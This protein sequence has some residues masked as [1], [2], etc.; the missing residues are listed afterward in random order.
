MK[1]WIAFLLTFCLLVA[2]PLQAATPK[3][4]PS[5]ENVTL[6]KP[7]LYDLATADSYATIT[8][9][10][11]GVSLTGKAY[12]KRVVIGKGVTLTLKD[13]HIDSSDDY[14][15]ITA[16]G[17]GCGLVLVG[18]NN[19]ESGRSYAGVNVP[20]TA[21]LVI[22]GSGKLT[23]RSYDDGAGIGGNSSQSN[24]RI[25]IRNAT[26]V[27]TG[28]GGGAGI[29]G[30]YRGNGSRIAIINAS[31]TA[32]SGAAGIGGGYRGNGSHIAIVNSSVT[33][34][35][36]AA[37]IGGGSGDDSGDGSHIA[38][39]N[40]SVTANGREAGIGGGYSRNGS[41]IVITASAVKAVGGIG[42]AGI[43]GGDSGNGSDITVDTV[44][45][46]QAS[47]G[48]GNSRVGGGGGA[49]IGGG[50]G[51]NAGRNGVYGGTA[52]RINIGVA[53]A[54]GSGGG[55]GTAGG[56]RGA[57]CGHGGRSSVGD[58]QNDGNSTNGSEVGKC[59]VDKRKNID[60]ALKKHPD[61]AYAGDQLLG[62]PSSPAITTEPSNTMFTEDG[63]ASFSVTVSGGTGTLAYQ[64]QV[65]ASGG[66]W[67]DIVDDGIY[68]GATTDTLTL[69]GA[70]I[71]DSGKQY[72]CVVN[73][74]IWQEAIS[75][76]ATLT[77]PLAFADNPSVLPHLGL[78]FYHHD[79]ELVCDN[80]RTCRAVGYHNEHDENGYY[81]PLSVLLTRKAGSNEPVTGRLMI[82]HYGYGDPENTK[83]HVLD[84]LPSV[85]KLFLRV[86]GKSVGKVTIS[87]DSFVSDLT[88]NQVK[89]LLAALVRDS[90]IELIDEDEANTWHL[91]DKGAA[92]VLLKMDEYQGRISTPGALVR[93][94]QK[95]EDSVLPPLPVPVVH[96]APVHKPLPGDES[97]VENNRAALLEAIRAV[98]TIIDDEGY[99]SSV[100]EGGSGALRVIA[101]LT[102]TKMLVSGECWSAAYNFGE[103]FWV[104][105]STPPYQPVLVT[106]D[107]GGWASQ[108][109]DGNI[110]SDHSH[111]II[112]AAH[113]GRGLGDCWSGDEWTWDGEQFVHT[114]SYSTGMCR[115]V[116]WGGAWKLPTIVTKAR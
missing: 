60:V 9:A 10:A 78:S 79:W 84:S 13:A 111:G 35:G 109:Y 38:I 91:S 70:P 7:G 39:V 37:G 19:A 34:N 12:R 52:S 47:G 96:A 1:T 95:D 41:N 104:I 68:S 99:C 100:D 56:G 22:K 24:G 23:A 29:G 101:R 116:T 106:T 80:T 81:S 49:G 6:N 58:A 85:F 26:I 107:G 61:R 5:G 90:R 18:D 45:F 69:T 17:M 54:T 73:D 2:L 59:A 83:D 92:A 72:R 32:S 71:T 63:N 20:D 82:G 87:K 108:D 110:R 25:T 89:A 113:K 44:S 42:G 48:A 86:N 28:D 93:K 40:S 66:K 103:G 50:G 3:P 31:V 75:P 77:P 51:G 97:F 114:E 64:W 33:A 62:Y 88:P 98:T 74:S 4:I 21:S 55:N 30:G 67:T 53:L 94:G 14:A 76:V 8:V 15:A 11:N 105:N 57:L 36:G 46:V 112:S 43:G 16:G 115:G 102:E 27:A 65:S